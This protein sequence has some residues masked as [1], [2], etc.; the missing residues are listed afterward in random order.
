M[1]IFCSSYGNHG[2]NFSMKE[3]NRIEAFF[4]TSSFVDP[5]N[6]LTT[7]GINISGL[8]KGQK[9]KLEVG[10]DFQCL[11][12]DDVMYIINS[13]EIAAENRLKSCILAA[14]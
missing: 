11:K 12:E 13:T 7:S 9:S 5:F 8:T 14:I 4:K 1:S 6:F 2:S 3:E 10:R